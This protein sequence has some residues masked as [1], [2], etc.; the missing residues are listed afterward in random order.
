MTTLVILFSSLAS[1]RSVA[2][3]TQLVLCS[4]TSLANFV[5]TS[6]DL[7][8]AIFLVPCGS[9]PILSL[10]ATDH[11]LVCDPLP[12][13]SFGI[14]SLNHLLS[15][16]LVDQWLVPIFLPFACDQSVVLSSWFDYL[17]GWTLVSL[18]QLVLIWL[19]VCGF[20]PSILVGAGLT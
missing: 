3:R 15:L 8:H 6:F 9:Q 12:L 4:R 7:V 17:R 18:T 19:L 5:H 20:D 10:F 2:V 16:F 14:A 11:Y 1:C 13:V